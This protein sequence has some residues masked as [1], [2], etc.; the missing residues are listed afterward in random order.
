MERGREE[1]RQVEDE[2]E[3]KKEI[4]TLREEGMRKAMKEGME[5]EG[6]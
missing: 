1:N 6:F 5:E 2:R 3:R 4:T